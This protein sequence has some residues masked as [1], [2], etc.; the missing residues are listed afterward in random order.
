M[1]TIEEIKEA[2]ENPAVKK[3]IKQHLKGNKYV[4]ILR[5]KPAFGGYVLVACSILSLIFPGA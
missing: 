5:S 1:T 4:A 3:A 2:L